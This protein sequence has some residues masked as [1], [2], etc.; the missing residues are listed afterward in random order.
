MYSIISSRCIFFCLILLLICSTLV[1]RYDLHR[2]PFNILRKDFHSHCFEWQSIDYRLPTTYACLYYS[3]MK[4]LVWTY[5]GTGIMKYVQWIVTRKLG[6]IRITRLNNNCRIIKENYFSS[7]SRD[8]TFIQIYI[9]SLSS[10]FSDE[11]ICSIKIN[12]IA[13]INLK[14]INQ[15]YFKRK[16]LNATVFFQQLDLMKHNDNFTFSTNIFLK[17]RIEKA[18]YITNRFSNYFISTKWTVIDSEDLIKANLIEC[19]KVLMDFISLLG[20]YKSIP[21]VKNIIEYDSH[22]FMEDATWWDQSE[23]AERILNMSIPSR[24]SNFTYSN[25]FY[26]LHGNRPFIQYL[27][28]NRQCYNAGIFTQMQFETITNRS[29]TDKPDRCSSKPFDCAFSDLYSFN[30]REQIYQQFDTS[31]YF[32]NK[33]VKC[34]FIIPSIFDK[35]RNRYGRNH[36]CQTIIFTCVTNCYDPLPEVESVI[37]HSFCF[38]ALLDTKTINTY[39]KIY[40]TNASIKWDLFD[41]GTDATPFS[42]AAKSVETLKIVGQRMFPLAKWI[43]W[44][45]GKA[46]IRNISELLLQVQAPV[47]GVAH[48][49]PGRT[50]ANEVGPT[51]GHLQ[52][53]YKSRPHPHDNW[54]LDI[55]LQQQEYQRDGFYSRSDALQLKMYDIAIFLYRNNH[56]CIFRY[57]CGW[58][59]EVNYFSYRGQLSV[60]Y[61]AVR[62]NLTNYL[63]ILPAK[64]YTTFSHRQVC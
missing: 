54:K 52:N 3:Q 33:S 21:I 17:E 42:A 49:D 13:N 37:L 31:D 1:I 56:P 44:L 11:S 6:N 27:F 9:M 22:K 58:H 19:E 34:G 28:E 25:D 32:N 63:H 40:P 60:Y 12:Q 23:V 35:V 30:D 45:D 43:I 55:T 4:S 51:I 50:S 62:F 41:L 36:T 15:L 39:K 59:N 38:V 18:N 26:Y 53:R 46:K 14:R 57:L 64:F 5:D 29:S 20:L 24:S 7:N 48:P 2:I 10:N 8:Y 61:A 47:I 16:S